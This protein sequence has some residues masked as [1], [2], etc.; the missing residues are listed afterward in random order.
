LNEYGSIKNI[1]KVQSNCTLLVCYQGHHGRNYN[2]NLGNNP[3][4]YGR[5]AAVGPIEYINND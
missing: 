4:F 5:K 1:I 3:Q 2:N